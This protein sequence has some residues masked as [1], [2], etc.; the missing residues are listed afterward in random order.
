MLGAKMENI[1]MC[2][3]KGVISTRRTDLNAS[4]KVF[5]TSLDV[6]TLAEAIVGADV[7]LTF[8]LPMC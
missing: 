1:I 7:F 8:R 2:D 4:K 5:A 6:N 3:S